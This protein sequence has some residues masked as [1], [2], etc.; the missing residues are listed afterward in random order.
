MMIDGLGALISTLLRRFKSNLDFLFQSIPRLS[1][2]NQKSNQTRILD[3]G[4]NIYRHYAIII[5]EH[6]D[7]KTLDLRILEDIGYG[8]DAS[9]SSFFNMPLITLISVSSQHS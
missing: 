8:Y 5:L 1:D 7:C 6:D 4:Q 3:L 9:W 2:A